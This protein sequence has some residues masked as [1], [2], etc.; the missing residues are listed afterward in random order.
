MGGAVISFLCESQKGPSGGNL[1]TKKVSD[2]FKGMQSPRAKRRLTFG[3]AN[4]LF[5]SL[6]FHPL[7]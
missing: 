4:I 3:Y 2:F 7:F 6:N 1:R 5:F